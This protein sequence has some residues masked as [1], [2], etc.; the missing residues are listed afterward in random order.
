MIHSVDRAGVATALAFA[1]GLVQGAVDLPIDALIRN[2]RR[3]NAAEA[4][5]ALRVNLAPLPAY[6]SKHPDEARQR[7]SSRSGD[8]V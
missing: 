7:S 4:G 3:A 1:L 2:I 8:V 5:A 6:V